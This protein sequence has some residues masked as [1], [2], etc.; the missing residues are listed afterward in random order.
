MHP[1]LQKIIPNSWLRHLFRALKQPRDT[2]ENSLVPNPRLAKHLASLGVAS[3]RTIDR[4][5]E[6]GRITI[7]GRAAR[8]GDKVNASN[9]ICIDGNAIPDVRIG[10]RPRVLLYHKPEGEISTRKD[11]SN[12]PTV[13]RN[14]PKLEAERWVAV[15]RL[16]IN[17]RGLLLFTNDGGLA[18]RLMHPS[19]NHEREYLCRVYGVATSADVNRLKR[20]ILLDDE[21]MCFNQVH[22]KRSDIAD[23]GRNNWYSVV[24]T[25]GKNREIRRMW[26]AVGCRISRLI[27]VRYGSIVLP[28]KLKMGEWQELKLAAVDTLLEESKLSLEK[29]D[30]ASE[31]KK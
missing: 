10:G 12:R 29:N 31:A 9:H 24:V 16:D 25:E 19:F 20:G 2:T 4:W 28:K 6:L 3:R 14:L 5:I 7:D 30:I 8:L 17:T 23:G 1:I 11:P 21:W 15:G 22:L 18:N 26:A 13:F 27:R